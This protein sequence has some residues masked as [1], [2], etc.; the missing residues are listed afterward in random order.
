[1][2]YSY[3]RPVLISLS[4]KIKVKLKLNYNIIYKP[5]FSRFYKDIIVVASAKIP[6]K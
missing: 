5:L 1:M 4:G 6:I 2:S 3:S